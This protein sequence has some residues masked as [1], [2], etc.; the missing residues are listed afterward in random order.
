MWERLFIGANLVMDSPGIIEAD[1]EQLMFLE[2]SDE[3]QLLVTAEVYDAQDR[4]VAKLRRNAWAFNDRDLCMV[5]TNPSDLTLSRKAD[6]EAGAGAEIPP[7]V[8]VA[9][10]DRSTVSVDEAN[11]YTKSGFR[12]VVTPQHTSGFTPSSAARSSTTPRSNTWS[13]RPAVR[14]QDRGDRRSSSQAADLQSW[15]VAS[16]MARTRLDSNLHSASSTRS[17]KAGSSFI[18][19]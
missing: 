6:E 1:G 10:V 17:R 9:V 18:R 11:L 7:M 8:R 14:P 5:T 2:L 19:R 15:S 4:H 12:I 16:A 3:G 13:L